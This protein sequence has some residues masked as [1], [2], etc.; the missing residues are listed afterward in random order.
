MTPRRRL[1]GDAPSR[2][3]TVDLWY[4]RIIAMTCGAIEDCCY[5]E[6]GV[7]Y[8]ALSLQVIAPYSAESHGCDLKPECNVP[9]G[10]QL[11]VMSSEEFLR[12]YDGSNPDVVFI[13]ADHDYDAVSADFQGVANRWHDA[14]VFLHDSWPINPPARID[15]CGE[16]YRLR[17]ELESSPD[18]ETFT[19]RQLPGLTIV[20]IR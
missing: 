16:V 5:I 20:R 10:T 11:W 14:T 2:D 9:Q 4:A 3:T 18:Y 7:D 17:E 12:I 15:E 13:D 8:E 1:V 19:W 6:I